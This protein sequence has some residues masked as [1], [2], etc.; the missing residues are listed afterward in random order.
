MYYLCY[1]IVNHKSNK[2]FNIAHACGIIDSDKYTNSLEAFQKSYSYGFRYIEIDIIEINGKHIIGAHDIDHFK[3]IS[4]FSLNNKLDINFIK[5]AKILNKYHIIY[6]EM[7]N[8]LLDTYKDV[9]IF[10]DKITNYYLLKKY[11]KFVD[12][13]FVE[14]FNYNQYV[15]AKNEGFKN[16]MLNIRHW[17]D[18]KK[19]LDNNNSISAITVGPSIFYKYRKLL[20]NIFNKRIKIFAFLINNISIIKSSYCRI[21]NGFYLD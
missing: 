7:I 5:K 3:V 20:K 19:L 9:N 2:C 4:N 10:T 18:L 1:R 15:S 13:L 14:V 17:N 16:V 8:K 6:D 21:V 12:R 11:G